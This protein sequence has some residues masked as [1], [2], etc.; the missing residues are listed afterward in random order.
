MSSND[1]SGL[2]KF[3]DRSRTL[4][5]TLRLMNALPEMNMRNSAKMSGKLAIALQVKGALSR[6]LTTL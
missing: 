4:Y 2:R 1:G 5:E 6:Y 3:A